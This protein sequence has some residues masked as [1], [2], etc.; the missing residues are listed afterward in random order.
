MASMFVLSVVYRL[1]E[2]R[3]GNPWD[4]AIGICCF[5]AKHAALKKNSKDWLDLNQDNVSEWDGMYIRGGLFLWASPI[6][7]TKRVDLVLSSPYH[8]F[9]DNQLVI[10]MI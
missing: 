2:P 6:K 4:Y 5:S 10:A 1:L 7:S 8:H 3:S 9:I